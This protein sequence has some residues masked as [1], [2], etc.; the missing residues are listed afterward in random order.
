MR[1]KRD[2]RLEAKWLEI[3]SGYACSGLTVRAY[4][5]SRQDAEASF[6]FWRRRAG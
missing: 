4:Y 6:L 3:A 5:K 2:I 1:G